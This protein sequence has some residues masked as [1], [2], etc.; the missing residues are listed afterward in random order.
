MTA[1]PMTGCLTGIR[2]AC[3]GAVESSSPSLVAFEK[4]GG[5]NAIWRPVAESAL[6][7]LPGTIVSL[8]D[9]RSRCGR[10]LDHGFSQGLSFAGSGRRSFFVVEGMP[11]ATVVLPSQ[12][13]SP[14][15]R[16]HLVLC[17]GVPWGTGSASAFALLCWTPSLSGPGPFRR[18][19]R[20]TSKQMRRSLTVAALAEPFRLPTPRR[21]LVRV[22][23]CVAGT[24]SRRGRTARGACV[25]RQRPRRRS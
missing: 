21:P 1:T 14:A 6:H 12:T 8:G 23:A 18:P 15:N 5:L 2:H 10:A 3:L 16:N 9:R 4:R 19:V 17:V 11:E 7:F 20:V 24:R 22:V 13:A 25:R